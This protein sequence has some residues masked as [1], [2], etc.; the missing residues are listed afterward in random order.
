MGA[1]MEFTYTYNGRIYIRPMGRG[2][3]LLDEGD[4]AFDIY[5]DEKLPMEGKFQAEIVIRLREVE[6]DL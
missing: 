4:K 6:N 2:I 5:L 1:K 3:A